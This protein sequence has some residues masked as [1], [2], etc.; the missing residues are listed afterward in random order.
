MASELPGAMSRCGV[1]VYAQEK[2]YRR[3]TL[4]ELT[5][6]L[7]KTIR[8]SGDELSPG[9]DNSTGNS[10]VT[11]QLLDS[12]STATRQDSS[13]KLDSCSTDLDSYSTETP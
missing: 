7:K 1:Y 11:R 12:Y 8:I 6:L 4:P 13:T 5:L 10:T 3:Q 2:R 9:L